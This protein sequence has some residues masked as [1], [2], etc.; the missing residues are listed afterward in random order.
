MANSVELGDGLGP[1]KSIPGRQR[2]QRDGVDGAETRSDGVE[3]TYQVPRGANDRRRR[4]IR[5]V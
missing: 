5:R 2:K 4:A 1:S 3:S